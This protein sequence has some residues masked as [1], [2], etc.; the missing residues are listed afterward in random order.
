MKN[1]F[2]IGTRGSDLALRQA[3]WVKALLKERYPHNYFELVKIKTRGDKI[4]DVP[5]ANVGGK[6]LFIKEIE[7]ALLE[8]RID[9]AVHSMKDVPT[10]L[11][12]GL[13]LGAVTKR[14]NPFD[15]LIAH[16]KKRLPE[17]PRGARIGTSSLRRQAQLL[18]FRPDFTVEPLRGNLDTRIKKLETENLDGIVVAASGL[19]RMGWE[20]KITEYL[21]QA[22]F[23]PAIGQGALGIETRED[24]SETDELIYFLHHHDTARTVLAERS[25]LKTLEGGC[26]VPVA[27][28]G[29][30]DKEKLSLKG[31]IGSLD[32]KVILC[33]KMEDT[34]EKAEEIGFELGEKL[35][36]AGGKSILE[37]IYQRVKPP[38]VQQL[39]NA[40]DF[41]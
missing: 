40:T 11:P 3:N 20:E 8:G 27:A 13:K 38:Q 10:V 31:M 32:G 34:K 18:N 41:L 39:K 37:E 22:K 14:E 24:D 16:Q 29:I 2:Y 7:E 17:L 35:L 9:L 33:D 25:F 36:S 30:I 4:R 1:T 15:A 5:L 26:Q 19:I 23:L 12:S 6:G 21:Y 28:F